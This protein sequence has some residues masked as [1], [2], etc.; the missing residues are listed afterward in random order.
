MFRISVAVLL[1]LVCGCASGPVSSTVVSPGE[2]KVSYFQ[3]AKGRSAKAPI[4]VYVAMISGERNMKY[5]LKL[6]EI[7]EEVNTPQVMVVDDE[8][9]G[10]LFKFFNHEEFFAL[11]ETPLAQFNAN[12]L[13]RTDYFTKVISAEINGV[14]YSVCYDNLDQFNKE[15]F[16]RIQQA[17][18]LFLTTATPKAAIQV[19]DWKELLP[20]EIQK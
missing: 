17:I 13:K 7:F 1:L 8:T 12:D 5:G 6:N 4:G 3:L 9:A 16:S 2:I 14:S 15:K 19:Q 18:F 11:P 10:E 20:E